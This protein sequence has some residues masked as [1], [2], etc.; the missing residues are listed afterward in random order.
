MRKGI[1]KKFVSYLPMNEVMST[2]GTILTVC[3]IIYV[4][5][6]R[7]L[8]EN[9]Y[10]IS[11]CSMFIIVFILVWMILFIIAIKAQR[12]INKLNDEFETQEYKKYLKG[13]KT[14]AE[15]KLSDGF[16]Q[17]GLVTLDELIDIEGKLGTDED[18][19]SCYVLIYTS[20]LATEKEAEEIVKQNIKKGV[21]YYVLYFE[22]SCSLIENKNIMDLYEKENLI[23]LSDKFNDTFDS[24]ASVS[25]GFDIMIY[26]DSK[27]KM[28][29]FFAVD[30]APDKN[31][32]KLGHKVQCIE[33]NYGK[34]RA[35]KD[36]NLFYKEISTETTNSLYNE[37]MSYINGGVGD[38]DGQ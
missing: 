23:D 28:R 34:Q 37:I 29:G 10:I 6:I 30:F 26:V 14:C 5:L 31:R 38:N 20:D 8:D 15:K 36:V 9:L 1:F 2:L 3:T 16:H 7:N 35:G 25:L 24:K 12:K 18:P 13:C 4:L 21:K 22:N 19:N 11:I 33:C 32:V 27:K 17:K